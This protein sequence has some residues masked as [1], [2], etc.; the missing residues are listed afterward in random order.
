MNKIK[1]IWGKWNKEGIR[2]PFIHDPVVNR[3]SITIVFPYVLFWICCISLISLHFFPD[4]VIATWTG[5]GFW[6]ISTILYMFRK[7]QKAKFDLDSKSIEI[8]AS[9]DK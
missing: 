1:E 3:P 2:L 5:I 4:L 7:L 8:E 9:D 6:T